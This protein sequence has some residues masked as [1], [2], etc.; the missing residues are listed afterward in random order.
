MMHFLAGITVGVGL[1]LVYSW[2]V[3]HGKG[4]W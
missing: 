2:A 3:L 4:F 1:V